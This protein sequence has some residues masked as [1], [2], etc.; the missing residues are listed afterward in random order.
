MI[1]YKRGATHLL[2]LLLILIITAFPAYADSIPEMPHAFYGTITCGGQPAPAGSIVVAR[3]DGVAAGTL[4]LTEAGKMGSTT[5]NQV[6]MLV[7]A[8]NSLGGHT[9][10]FYIK[11]SATATEVKADQTWIFHAGDVTPLDL[12]SG[13][14]PLPPTTTVPAGGGGGG[15]G[16]PATTAPA[17]TKPIITPPQVEQNPANLS[18][19]DLEILTPPIIAAIL[20]QVTSPKDAEVLSAMLTALAAAVVNEPSLTVQK[21]IEIFNNQN[22]SSSEAAKILPLINIQKAV[23][24]SNGLSTPKLNDI[25]KN[26]SADALINLLPKMDVNVLNKLPYETLF[27]VLTKVDPNNLIKEIPP[28]GLLQA[29]FVINTLNLIRTSIPQTQ[30]DD[31]VIL[32]NKPEQTTSSPNNTGMARFLKSFNN[33]G[34]LSKLSFAAPKNNNII[35]NYSSSVN[36]LIPGAGRETLSSAVDTTELLPLI[37]LKIRVNAALK[38]VETTIEAISN[39][40]QAAKIP[41]GEAVY[42]F[43]NISQKNITPGQMEVGHLA[44]KVYKKWLSANNINEWSIYL[45]RYDDQAAKWVRLPTIK[46]EETKEYTKYHA[47]I[48]AFSLF[49]VTGQQTL[50]TE[51]FSASNLSIKPTQVKVGEKVN[52]SATIKNDAGITDKY[53]ASGWVNYTIEAVKYFTLSKGES[54][55]FSF[56][57]TP[58]EAGTFEVRVGRQVGKYEV[59]PLVVPTST[60]PPITP[61]V[62]APTST[63]APPISTPPVTPPT[64]IAPTGGIPWWVWLII[65]IVILIIVGYFVRRWWILRY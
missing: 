57:I 12:I 8:G 37:L 56:T 42:S 60:A 55:D 58:K 28:Q 38:N 20:A 11:A 19:P 14:L 26:M 34:N 52:V 18:R 35:P 4:T 36:Q 3:V 5:S 10:E 16:V 33:I 61:S 30:P 25:V 43:F 46:K 47:A 50:P 64:T 39:P 17:T 51:E 54:G 1:T 63:V 23:D 32:L 6:P 62:T 2:L 48:N 9:I 22:M 41:S 7:V 31:W 21:L 40:T 49:C 15:G 13:A 45:N 27:N 65:A 53:V 44:F 29:N 24:I 59:L